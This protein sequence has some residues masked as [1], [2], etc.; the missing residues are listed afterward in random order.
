MILSL[1]GNPSSLT[2]FDVTVCAEAQKKEKMRHGPETI[3]SRK[4]LNMEYLWKNSKN[5]ARHVETRF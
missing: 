5:E 2:N 3:N 4:R 1:T